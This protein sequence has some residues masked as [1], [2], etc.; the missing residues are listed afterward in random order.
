MHNEGFGYKA[1]ASAL[2][3]SCDEIRA[4]CKRNG[5][6]GLLGKVPDKRPVTEY[7]KGAY[8]EI[9]QNETIT[10]SGDIWR[11]GRHRLM[12]GDIVFGTVKESGYR[13]YNTAYVEIPKKSGK[14]ELA[15]AV[16]LYLTC[17]EKTFRFPAAW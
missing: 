8:D 5:L 12:C 10:K 2:G 15:A 1:I 7:P 13:Q 14:S 6:A 11:L 17:A 3:K 4:F 16:A 9:S